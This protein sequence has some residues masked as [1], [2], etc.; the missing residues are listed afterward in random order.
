[1][2]DKD[3]IE[4]PAQENSLLDED[5][6]TFVSQAQDLITEITKAQVFPSSPSNTSLNRINI[7]SQ[8][9]PSNPNFSNSQ[10]IK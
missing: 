1:M 8:F 4:K 2:N 5:I 6:N 7:N 3:Q 9:N 10:D